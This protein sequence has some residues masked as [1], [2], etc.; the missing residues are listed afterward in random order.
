MQRSNA[1]CRLPCCMIQD[2]NGEMVEL[3]F[4]DKIRRNFA[5]LFGRRELAISTAHPML[6]E[7]IEDFI[8]PSYD[9]DYNNRF[10][11]T[12]NRNIRNIDET[13]R[14]GFTR[15][16]PTG[17]IIAFR[18]SSQVASRSRRDALGDPRASSTQHHER[19]RPRVMDISSMLV[20]DDTWEPSSN[21]S[22]ASDDSFID[23]IGGE[24]GSAEVSALINEEM[25]DV[26]QQVAD[27]ATLARNA[28][29]NAN[30]FREEL[31]RLRDEMNISN[32]V[33]PD[34][35]SGSQG[36]APGQAPG[37]G[38]GAQHQAGAPPAAPPLPAPAPIRQ[39]S[40]FGQPIRQPLI[41]GPRVPPPNNVPPMSGIATMTSPARPVMGPPVSASSAAPPTSETLVRPPGPAQS[42]AAEISR[43][44]NV[45]DEVER[46]RSGAGQGGP[47]TGSGP[48][49]QTGARP[50]SL[51][52]SESV[53][54]SENA[55]SELASAPGS[56][57]SSVP[58]SGAPPS[59]QLLDSGV[60]NLLA[61]R[62]EIIPP[63]TTTAIA[64]PTVPASTSVTTSRLSVMHT[65]TPAPSS[66]ER[67]VRFND[68]NV[69][70]FDGN[71]TINEKSRPGH[72]GLFEANDSSVSDETEISTTSLTSQTSPA[73]AVTQ[74]N[75]S[76]RATTEVGVEETAQMSPGAGIDESV[77]V[78]PDTG[79]NESVQ[80]AIGSGGVNSDQGAEG[81]NEEKSNNLFIMTELN[82]FVAALSSS[83]IV[84]HHWDSMSKYNVYVSSQQ[85]T[86]AVKS[87]IIGDETTDLTT[88]DNPES[89]FQLP[90]DQLPNELNFD[91]VL[92][93]MYLVHQRS[94][95]LG[96]LTRE[97]IYRVVINDSSFPLEGDSIELR[98]YRRYLLISANWD[99]KAMAALLRLAQVAGPDHII[100]SEPP[101]TQAEEMKRHLE[102]FQLHNVDTKIQ[103][104]YLLAMMTRVIELFHF[105][106]GWRGK[107]R[108]F[109]NTK[110]MRK[111][112]TTR[113]NGED[114]MELQRQLDTTTT[115]SVASDQSS[116]PSFQES[117]FNSE[118]LRDLHMSQPEREGID[119]D[120]RR[121]RFNLLRIG[122]AMNQLDSV[123]ATPRPETLGPETSGLETSRLETSRLETP[124]PETWAD[125]TWRG[126]YNL[127]N[128]SGI[129]RTP[130]QLRGPMDTDNPG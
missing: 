91:D 14:E 76:D 89:M 64:A 70:Q 78:T 4:P 61:T 65:S 68:D 106:E 13:L 99:N 56:L 9:D 87:V 77:Q 73:A 117:M 24:I 37:T 128:I 98:Y 38:G 8:I 63:S 103:F 111:S 59:I 60:P 11:F 114:F 124:R 30:R 122:D 95:R 26:R 104:I 3:S 84:S 29:A 52:S 105:D 107:Q 32:R 6:T 12:A 72:Y 54:S 92:I 115:E 2:Q 34:G 55:G 108:H 27:M 45:V 31:N 10:P 102:N 97:P 109:F 41:F 83:D 79:V 28:E 19:Q 69:P 15:V 88:L 5:D 47:G 129:F 75:S 17:R 125:I 116:G 21:Q 36:V 110:N 43:L 113:V 42:E 118:H 90:G 22:V 16:D 96:L 40:I 127:G 67:H 23:T 18:D 7:E 71:G 130:G 39:P 85:V 57:T 126:L 80:V 51:A 74:N 100:A 1:L 33:Q 101:P 119:N 82:F 20:R 93:T 25:G 62:L 94:A 120:R 86:I 66:S 46:R 49:R 50:R 53:A 123:V 121:P 112:V 35:Q 44:S 48:G 81:G 58:V